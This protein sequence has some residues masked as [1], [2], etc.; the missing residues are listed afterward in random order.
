MPI[1][2]A[3]KSKTRKENSQPPDPTDRQV[4]EPQPHPDASPACHRKIQFHCQLAQGSPTGVISDF[5]TVEQLYSKI[6]GCYGID[7]AEVV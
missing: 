4:E 5:T 7:A 6:A 1:F 2:G 3:K